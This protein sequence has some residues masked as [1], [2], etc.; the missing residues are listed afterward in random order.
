MELKELKGER[1]RILAGARGHFFSHG[2]RAVTMDDL[3]RDLGMSKKTLYRHFSSKHEILETLLTSKMADAEADLTSVVTDKNLDF[4]ERL[5]RMLE[6]VRRHTSEL[7][8]TFLRDMGRDM[9]GLFAIVKERR[10]HIIRKH[11][12]A[13]MEEGM[14]KGL[15][16]RDLPLEMLLGMLIGAADAVVN[17]IR[18]SEM[19]L[20]VQ[21]AYGMIVRTFLAGIATEKG[22]SKL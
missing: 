12:G 11:W 10:S 16:R 1:G 18:L 22:R 13:L 3:A 4:P 7:S 9:P 14:R 20:T 21:E 5:R 19:G 8:P 6:C 17:P 2:F 15:V